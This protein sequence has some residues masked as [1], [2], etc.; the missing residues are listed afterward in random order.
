MERGY[1][2]NLLH[3]KWIFPP[4]QRTKLKVEIIANINSLLAS[5]NLY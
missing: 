5:E 3:P 4:P 2:G 1:V